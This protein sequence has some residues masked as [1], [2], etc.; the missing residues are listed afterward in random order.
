VGI[1]SS[2]IQSIRLVFAFV[3]F[4]FSLFFFSF[5]FFFAPHSNHKSFHN[6]GNLTHTSLPR[7]YARRELAFKQDH[8]QRQG[9]LSTMA[10][11][12]LKLVFLFKSISPHPTACIPK[13]RVHVPFVD[14]CRAPCSPDAVDQDPCVCAGG[15][16]GSVGVGSWG[17]CVWVVGR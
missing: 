2:N 15:Y 11:M 17:R 16:F 6:A 5:P 9:L 3:C 14:L 7:P 1:P 12:F 4:Y 8:T 13:H 10:G